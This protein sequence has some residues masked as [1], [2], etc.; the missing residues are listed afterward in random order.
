M[1]DYEIVDQNTATFIDVLANDTEFEGEALQIYSTSV[2]THGEVSIN[3]DS[4]LYTPNTDYVGADSF[5]Y[6]ITDG[7]GG[8]ASNIVTVDVVSVNNAPIALADSAEVL[9]RGS[10]TIDVLA[11]DSD[12]EGAMLTV[13][14]AGNGGKGTTTVNANGTI[15][16]TVSG[17]N[18]GGDSF[19]YT[20]SDGEVRSTAVVTLAIVRRLSSGGDTST[21]TGGDTTTTTKCHPKKGC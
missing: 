18:R 2:A 19:T 12:P 9:L 8:F 13:V 7:V 20:V 14:S 10:V 15:T 3:G 11:N 17:K 5:E 21:D 4:I 1:S 16:Y 6:T